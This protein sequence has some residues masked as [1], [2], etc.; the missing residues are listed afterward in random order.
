MAKEIFEFTQLCITPNQA[1][2]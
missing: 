1:C 2:R